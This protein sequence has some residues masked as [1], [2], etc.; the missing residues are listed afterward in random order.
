MAGSGLVRAVWIPSAVGLLASIGYFAM[1]PFQLEAP[2]KPKEF[3]AS[4]RSF[5]IQHPGNWKPKRSGAHAVEDSIRFEP[6]KQVV[7]EM[8]S[9]LKGSLMADIARSG[10]NMASTLESSAEEAAREN[11]EL[12]RQFSQ[13]QAAEKKVEKKVEK[14]PVMKAHEMHGAGMEEDLKGY[15]ESPAVKT[16]LAGLE[17]AE[18][19]FTFQGEGL[20]RPRAMSGKRVTAL[21]NDRAIYLIYYGPQNQMKTLGPVFADMRN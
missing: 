13:L 20:W 11:P 2:A 3:V 5:S 19:D 12:A 4:D 18:S 17:A 14:S 21:T 16:T 8:Q 15:K 9:D 6:A 10:D 1:Q 7:F